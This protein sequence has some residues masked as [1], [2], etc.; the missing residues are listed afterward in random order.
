MIVAWPAEASWNPPRQREQRDPRAVVGGLHSD[1]MPPVTRRPALFVLIA[2]AL[3]LAPLGMCLSGGAAMAAPGHGP[4]MHH[5]GTTPASHH[6]QSDRGKLHFCPDCQPPSFVKG[7]KVAAPDVAPLNAAIAPP[8]A[9]R[10]LALDTAR[11]TWARGLSTR[12]PPLRRTYRIRLQ[13]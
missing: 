9:G 12:P 11:A 2:L 1:Y 4:A 3:L 7:G 6:K 13:I 10:P 8:V 5:G